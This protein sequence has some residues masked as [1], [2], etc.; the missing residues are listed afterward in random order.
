M[1]KSLLIC[2]KK[3][4]KFLISGSIGSGKGCYTYGFR[5]LNLV[6]MQA[7]DVRIRV[8]TDQS[9]SRCINFGQSRQAVSGS[10]GFQFEQSKFLI[11][12]LMKHTF[13]I[14]ILGDSD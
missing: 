10:V 12:F 11:L 5:W 14:M 6:F 4:G 7:Q 1:R 2:A 13:M 8:E 3:N 9:G